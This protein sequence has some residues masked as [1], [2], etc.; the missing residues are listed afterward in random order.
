MI[1]SIMGSLWVLVHLPSRV[2]VVQAN[3]QE[4]EAAVLAESLQ[5]TEEAGQVASIRG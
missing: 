5:P 2:A 3:E 1:A 4:P